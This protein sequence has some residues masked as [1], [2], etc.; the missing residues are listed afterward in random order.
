MATLIDYSAFGLVDLTPAFTVTSQQNYLLQALNIFESVGSETIK[1]SFDRIVE[2][3][4]SLLN[5]P[6]KRYSFEHNSTARGDATNFLIECPYFLR[7][8][9][10]S[11]ADFQRG[12]RRPG[13][14]EYD[15]VA[16]S[17]EGLYSNMTR[18]IVFAGRNVYNK[19]RFHPSMKSAFQYVS[20]LDV[21][22][23]ITK[24]R[25]LLPN[26]QTMTVPGLSLDV[27]SVADPLLTQYIGADEL[28]LVPIF[29][30]GTNAY[31]HIYTPASTNTKLARTGVAAEYF[32][33]MIEKDLGETDIYFEASI[34]PVNNV[35][36]SILKVSVKI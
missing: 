7:S 6:K 32:S 9:Q 5:D 24:R 19:L 3:N 21:E 36:S 33:Y 27:V 1:I 16:D 17:A 18:V 14:D 29:R 13:R 30:A 26:V 4:K 31:N 12:N 34:L 15:Q 35:T 20:P 8:D 25:E 28:I 23:I 2:S 10:V 22:N 11:A